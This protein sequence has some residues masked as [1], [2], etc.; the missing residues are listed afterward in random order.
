MPATRRRLLPTSASESSDVSG[1][2][3]AAYPC[4]V[5]ISC[6]SRL[7]ARRHGVPSADI[8]PRT[9]RKRLLRLI[10]LWSVCF[11]LLRTQRASPA[12]AGLPA[13]HTHNE[14]QRWT[15]GAILDPAAELPPRARQ[16]AS[17]AWGAVSARSDVS[18]PARRP[19]DVPHSTIGPIREQH[20][21]IK[22]EC[23]ACGTGLFDAWRASCVWDPSGRCLV[24]RMA[25]GIKGGVG[26]RER[27]PGVL[28]H[29]GFLGG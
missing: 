24:A 4:F 19:V 13:A 11:G 26:Y 25:Q 9:S 3:T 18:G 27:P 29:A 16:G 21:V 5:G 2:A 28:R 8:R 1:P 10:V 22:K 17:L 6:R 23:D 7:Q 20:N 14:A 15:S 12:A